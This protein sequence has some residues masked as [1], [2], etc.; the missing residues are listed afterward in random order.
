[1]SID[2]FHNALRILLNIDMFELEDAGVIATDDKQA[3]HE[4]RDNPFR[5]FI[6]VEDAKADRLWEI[7]EKR[8]Q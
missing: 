5:W 8:M 1:M 3:W 6:Y 4:F 7:M 2:E